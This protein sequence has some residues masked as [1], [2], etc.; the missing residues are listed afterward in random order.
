M[1]DSVLVPL[2]ALVGE[3]EL[4]VPQAPGSSGRAVFEW[5]EGGAYLL[6]R[7]YAPDPAPDSTWIIGADDAGDSCTALY[8]DERGVSRVYRTSLADG[9]WR[10]WREAPGFSQRFTGALSEDGA[11]IRGAWELSRDDSTWEHDFE[12]V[13]TRVR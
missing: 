13:Y 2:G 4:Q 12:L 10:V 5:L 9:V 7:S 1:A 8:H 6:Q 11:T 3:W